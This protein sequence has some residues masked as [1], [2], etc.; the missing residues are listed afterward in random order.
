MSTIDTIVI[1]NGLQFQKETT[2]D[3]WTIDGI[4]SAY[5]AVKTY[6]ILCP[7]PASGVRVIFNNNYDVGGASRIH[8][9][10]KVT[11]LT[12]MVGGTPTKTEN[13]QALEWTAVAAWAAGDPAAG[14]LETGA[15]DISGAIEAT[16]HIDVAITSTTAHTGTE[17]ICQARSEAALDEWTTFSNFIG[18]TGTATKS[19]FAAQEAVAQTTLSITNPTAGNLNH[20]PKFIFLEDTAAI[21]QCEIAYQTDF[22]A[23]A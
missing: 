22:G 14:I 20:V 2:S 21:A 7:V 23:D 1:L 5:E 12:S 4:G 6:D 13:T 10:V 3:V 8:V 15:I 16:L 11:K 19:D 17:I 18:P 9:R